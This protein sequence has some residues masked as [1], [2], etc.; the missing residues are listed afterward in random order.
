[1]NDFV[2]AVIYTASGVLAVAFAAFGKWFYNFAKA[3]KS[4]H[5]VVLGRP[6]MQGVPAVPSMVERFDAMGDH[7][8]KQDDK[9][10]TIEHE[11]T[12]NNG[13]SLKDDVRRINKKLDDHLASVRDG[14]K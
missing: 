7:L 2:T 11:V 4:I 3:Q 6:A 13:G 10:D 1:M 14:S 12:L 8:S 5:E 9:M